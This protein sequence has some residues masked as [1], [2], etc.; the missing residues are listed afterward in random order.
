MNLSEVD[1]TQ[2]FD[3]LGPRERT[4]ER[5]VLELTEHTYFPEGEPSTGWLPKVRRAFR[6]LAGSLSNGKIEHGTVCI[7]GCGPALDGILAAEILRPDYLVLT[8]VHEDVVATG[9]RNVLRNCVSQ[10]A[11]R[12]DAYVSD[13]CQ[14]LIYH[15]IKADLIYENL[16]NLATPGDV[17]LDDG[18]L[19][20]SFFAISETQRNIIPS[21]FAE[22]ML[23]LHYT[24]LM[25]ARECLRPGGEIISCIGARIPQKIIFRM[26]R[27]L[28]YSPALVV[29]DLVEQFEAEKVLAEYARVERD[30]PNMEFVFY[31]L[32]KGREQLRKLEERGVELERLADAMADLGISFNAQTAANRHSL[33]QRVA[34]LGLVIRG[35]LS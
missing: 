12:I 6:I 23:A 4:R 1:C 30:K 33:G 28:G 3:E 31:D 11:I 34:V 20:A 8:D 2:F 13:L 10:T 35:K 29:V 5:I 24:C 22:H 27:E 9:K 32:D 26:F 14:A 17:N 21:E 25:E 18:A 16:P 7:V 19:S 15:K